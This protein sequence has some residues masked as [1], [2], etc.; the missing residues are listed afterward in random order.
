MVLNVVKRS[1]LLVV[2]VYASVTT[3]S[4][5][6][7]RAGEATPL[8]EA[9][10]LAASGQSATDFVKK[11]HDD[12]QAAMKA[13]KDP[14]SDPTL[15]A[16]FDTMLD[17]DAIAQDSLD[18][19]WDAL[20]EAQRAEF[21]GLLKQLVQKSYRKNLRDP[22]AYAVEYTSTAESPKGIVVKTLAK[23]KANKREKALGINYL[24][25]ST[26]SGL[27][28]RDVVT[29]DVSLV[30]NYRSQFKRML[31]KRGFDGLLEQMRKQLE[32]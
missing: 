14:K 24:V 21:S 5:E 29:D 8:Q 31:K 11:K 1:L 26:A 18:G 32:K 2:G 7:A 30:G 19:E 10:G 15:L 6:T 12:L 17:Y 13:A 22:S 28:I 3:G 4:L 20:N 27:K 25:A 9:T 16:I 23:N